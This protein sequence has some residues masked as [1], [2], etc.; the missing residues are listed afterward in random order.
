MSC[1]PY[2]E[3]SELERNQLAC[4]LAAL[5]LHDE[6][7]DITSESISRIVS[8]SGLKLPEYWPLMMSKALEGQDLNSYLQVSGGG[9]G[10]AGPAN[11]EAKEEEK[12]EESEEEESEDMSMGGLFD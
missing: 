5:I 10:G 4:N 12:K 1:Q 9:S 6:K 8:H 11:N 2:K 3:L 7:S